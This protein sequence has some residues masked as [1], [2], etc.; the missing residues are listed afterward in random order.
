MKAK[1]LLIEFKKQD[2]GPFIEVP[3]SFLA[4]VIAE[5]LADPACEVIKPVNEAVAMGIAAGRYLAT[6]KVPMVLSQN[7]GLCNT[8]NCLTSLHQVYEL[9]TIYLVS[10]RG[11]PGIKDAPEHDVMGSKL[12]SILETFDIPYRVLSESGYA[13]E[14]D[15]VMA[16]IRKRRMPGALI[17]KKGLLEKVPPF[18]VHSHLP[19]TRSR[20]VEILVDAG[21][22]KA[23]FVTTNGFISREVFHHL[24][25]KGIEDENP[26]FYMLG[27]MGHALPLALGVEQSINGEGHVVAVDGDGGCL[28]HLGAMASVGEGRNSNLIHV[29]LDNGCYASTGGQP[30]VSGAVDL[31]AVARGCGYKEVHAADNED[32]LKAIFSVLLTRPGPAFVHVLINNIEGKKRHRISEKYTC[33]DI[34]NRFAGRIRRKNSSVP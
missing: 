10:W 24:A 5:M 11:E 23:H 25:E 7:S 27:S 6:G 26:H 9:P 15:A 28:M 20:A 2:I 13:G 32:A 17:V 22:E 4:P 33:P 18:S 21:G 30:T 16:E 8:L 31:C 14:I 19:M 3:C 12:L 34:K 29:V 1:Q